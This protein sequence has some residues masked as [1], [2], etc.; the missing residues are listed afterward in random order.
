[1]LTV[2]LDDR[3]DML[4][5]KAAAMEGASV[6]EFMRRAIA[7]RAE[8]ALSGDTNGRLADVIGAVHGGGTASARVSGDAFTEM[9]AE[10]RER[11]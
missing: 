1:V 8:R 9:L 4:A 2:R 11:S 6:S 5:R 10:R 7:E 3:L